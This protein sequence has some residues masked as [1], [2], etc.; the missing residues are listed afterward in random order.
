MNEL[1]AIQQR[2]NSTCLTYENT[3]KRTSFN[4]TVITQPVVC[5]VVQNVFFFHNFGKTHNLSVCV[6]KGTDMLLTILPGTV[7]SVGES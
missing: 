3:S 6:L 4:L 5:L 7:C 2:Q 1:Q